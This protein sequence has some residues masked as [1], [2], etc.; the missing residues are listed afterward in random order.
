MSDPQPMSYP[1]QVT[2]GKRVTCTNHPWEYGS[3]RFGSGWSVS[4][5]VESFGQEAQ[6]QGSSPRASKGRTSRK[7]SLHLRITHICKWR[8]D[9]TNH[10][11]IHGR[12]GLHHPFLSCK[13]EKTDKRKYCAYRIS[14][15]GLLYFKDANANFWLCIP[16]SEWEGILK[17]V[18]DG[19]KGG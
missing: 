18:H 6:R 1:P 8:Y 17:E 15:N 12:Q 16:A 3:R 2:C 11:R 19:Y 13:R 4:R 5:L 14:W 9:Q 10:R 7:F